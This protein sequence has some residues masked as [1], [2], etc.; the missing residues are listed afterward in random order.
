MSQIATLLFR[1]VTKFVRMTL[2]TLS[3]CITYVACL[4]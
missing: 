4:G 2:L 3:L 1:K